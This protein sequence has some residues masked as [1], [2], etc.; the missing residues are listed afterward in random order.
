VSETNKPE[1]SSEEDRG[2]ANDS[3]GQEPI[4]QRIVRF[5]E[6]ARRELIDISRRNRLL[7]APRNADRT[8]GGGGADGT[9]GSS[10]GALE[11]HDRIALSF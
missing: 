1:N 11:L 4:M 7:H 8:V 6:D 10:G 9:G 3:I 2:K 5:L